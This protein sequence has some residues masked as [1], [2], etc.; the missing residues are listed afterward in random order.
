MK[1]NIFKLIAWGMICSCLFSCIKNNKG[2]FERSTPE[3]EGVRTEGIIRFI[4]EA[5]ADS[6][7]MHS[8]MILRHG[9]IIAEGW[10]Y[11]YKSDINHIM[12]SVTKTF[13]STA[14]GFAIDE[15]LI[16]VN[17]KV[18]SFFPDDLPAEISPN[19]EALTVKHLLTM[20]VGQE[21][22]PFIFIS[23][24]NWVKA[25][26]ATPII[27]PPGSVFLYNSYSSHMLSAIIQKITGQTVSDYL[28]PRLFEPLNIKNIQWE[29][30]PQGINM[31]GWGMSI[32]TEDMAKLGQFYLQQGTWNGKQLLSKEWI[33]EASSVQIYQPANLTDEDKSNDEWVQG[34]GYQIWRCTHNAY[35]ADG[36][37]GQFIIVMPEQDAVV[38]I[39]ENVMGDAQKVLK[40]VFKYL[41]PSMTDNEYPDNKEQN[42]KLT[43]ILSSLL[44]PSPFHTNE[45]TEIMK[46]TTLSYSMDINNLQLQNISFKFD[47]EANCQL[48]LTI[49]GTS[50]EF[51][52]G[53][54]TWRYGETDKL[55]P[56][57]LFPRRNPV[58]LAPFTVVGYGSWIKKD[59]L[60]L[61][62]LYVND[63][64][65]ENY[66]CHFDG[67]KISITVSN[68]GDIWRKEQLILTGIIQ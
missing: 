1:I 38:V 25:F 23:E 7:D 37:N 62:L 47:K 22:A 60:N 27:N 55:S 39:T 33:N 42:K 15:K 59:E 10:W 20:S 48:T 57:F 45:K 32:K 43:S 19:L 14:I 46:D 52:F 4:E 67:N 54:D 8:L 28:K 9:K 61:R 49:G 51:P 3:K 36:S 5:Q 58:G 65:E 64:Q 21:P 66:V 29:I 53:L 63:Y 16:T 24:P 12:H 40:L 50:Y 56:Y 18:I 6:I 13:I 11:P 31:G 26:L 2:E 35:R 44:I 34:Y 68:T 17:D 41:L 30:D